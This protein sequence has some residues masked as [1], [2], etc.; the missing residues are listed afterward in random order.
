MAGLKLHQLQTPCSEAEVRSLQAGDMVS[1]NGLI[2]TGRDRLHKYLAEGGTLQSDLRN[3]AI[4]HCGPV[5]I[6]DSAGGWQVVAAGPT[7]SIREEPYMAQI[8]ERFGVRVI[9]GKGGMGEATAAACQ[10]FGC[11]YLQAVG[12][13]AALLA[14]CVREVPA[15]ELLDEFGAAEALWHFQVAEFE[16]VVGLD[17]HGGSIYRSVTTHSAYKLSQLIECKSS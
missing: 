8:I 7:T 6:P 10:K 13:A 5:I 16:A 2:Y 12:G 4:Y 1:L 3:S 17:T 14:Q 9:I 15:V 11:I